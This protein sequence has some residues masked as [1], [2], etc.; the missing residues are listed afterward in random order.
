MVRDEEKM[1]E[2]IVG[3]DKISYKNGSDEI[4]VLQVV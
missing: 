3:E 4:S 2:T 1:Q